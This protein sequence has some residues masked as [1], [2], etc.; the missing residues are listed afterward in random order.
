[1]A[2]TNSQINHMKNQTQISFTIP[3]Y[4]SGRVMMLDV[5]K[6]DIEWLTK[7]SKAYKIANLKIRALQDINNKYLQKQR[8]KRLH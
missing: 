8:F 7:N 4:N 2:T 6:E 1:M 5:L 3:K